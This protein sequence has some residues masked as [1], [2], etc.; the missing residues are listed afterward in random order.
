MTKKNVIRLFAVMLVIV[1]A[2]VSVYAADVS[3][4]D[5]DTDSANGVEVKYH[6][7]GVYDQEGYIGRT[8]AV[9]SADGIG[10]PFI[11]SFNGS[12]SISARKNTST[13]PYSSVSSTSDNFVLNDYMNINLSATSMDSYNAVEVKATFSANGVSSNTNSRVYYSGTLTIN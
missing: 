13:A 5:S 3:V 6:L 2:V 7:E 11:T 10:Y 1:I 9:L 4:Y 12:I 8:T